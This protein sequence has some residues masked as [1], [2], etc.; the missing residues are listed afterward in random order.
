M[1]LS[2]RA[3]LPVLI[4][5]PFRR[6]PPPEIL[7]KV[8]QT[9]LLF[10]GDVMLSRFVGSLARA[11][12]DPTWP[13][14]DLAPVLAAADIAFVNLEAPFSDRGP[15]VEHGMIF[16]TEPEMIRALEIAGIDVVST[17]NN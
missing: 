14:R 1:M 4:G 13:L 3:L 12:Q 2:R 17:A 8:I 5:I 9:R 7:P 11:K 15:L 16:K 6:T 10:G